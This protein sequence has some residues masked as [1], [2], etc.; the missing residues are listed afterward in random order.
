MNFGVSL[1]L[2]NDGFLRRQCPHC[3]AQFKWHH[4]PAN[5]EAENAANPSS[6]FCPHCGRPAETDRWFTEEQVDYINGVAAPAVARYADDILSDAFKGIKSRY[7]KFE[8]KGSL[9]TPAEPDA[10]VEP[11]DMMIVASPCHSYEP[12]K[13]PEAAGTLHCLVCGAPFTV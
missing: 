6:Y 12:V 2:D 5:E 3:N 10:L 1:P 11:D 8:M 4:G 13:V 9:D 7:V